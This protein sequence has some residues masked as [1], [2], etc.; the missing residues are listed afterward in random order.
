MERIAPPVYLEIGERV[1]PGSD[2]IHCS[3]ALPSRPGWTC[4][5]FV[6]LPEVGAMLLHTFEPDQYIGQ[7]QEGLSAFRCEKCGRSYVFRSPRVDFTKQSAI[8]DVAA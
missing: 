2:P 8:L 1:A 3:G 5:G 4:R 7:A 6:G